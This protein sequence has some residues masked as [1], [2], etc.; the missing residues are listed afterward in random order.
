MTAAA[1]ASGTTDFMCWGVSDPILVEELARAGVDARVV[2]ELLERLRA[3]VVRRVSSTTRVGAPRRPSIGSNGR[4]SS[5]PMTTPRRRHAGSGSWHWGLTARC[6]PAGPLGPH[7][8]DG[9]SWTIAADAEGAPLTGVH[10]RA[11][12]ERGQEPPGA[13]L[14]D[15]MRTGSKCWWTTPS[16]ATR[17]AIEA[18][19]GSTTTA[20][21]RSTSLASPGRDGTQ[22]APG[23]GVHLVLTIHGPMSHALDGSWNPPGVR[24]LAD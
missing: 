6:R 3:A 15:G 20:R 14:D 22:L 4:R 7:A 23:Q 2:G 9:V 16:T 17:S 8:V 1:C 21:S 18:T 19:S 5:K 24:C 10:S 11:H 12:F 13:V